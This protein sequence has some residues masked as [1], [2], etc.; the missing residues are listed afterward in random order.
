MA[1]AVVNT[2]R[3]VNISDAI[4]AFAVIAIVGVMIIP[5]PSPV[6]DIL[7]SFNIVFSIII[8]L[9]TM[10]ITRPLELSVF[11]G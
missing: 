7:L 2:Q 9:V 5:V 8:L 11:P 6:L 1:E 4:L 10:Y 3:N